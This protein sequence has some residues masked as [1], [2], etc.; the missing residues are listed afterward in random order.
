[1]CVGSE[2]NGLDDV[3]RHQEF[4]SQ[5]DG[6]AELF[7]KYAV[8]LPRPLSEVGNDA[9]RC[10]DRSDGHD[11]HTDTVDDLAD[12]FN[13]L[14]EAHCANC[15]VECASTAIIW[16][17]IRSGCTFAHSSHIEMAQERLIDSAHT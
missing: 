14:E 11:G 6:P 5:Q 4:Q 8:G 9:H 1:M 12:K 16:P 2:R 7:V 17:E 13:N 10:D 15:A 3:G